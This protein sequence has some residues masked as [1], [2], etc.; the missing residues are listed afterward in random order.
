MHARELREQPISELLRHLLQQA[1]LLMQ[2]ALGLARH[3]LKNQARDAALCA[4]LFAVAG[5]LGTLGFAALTAAFVLAL[6]LALPSW[7]AALIVAV[8]YGAV[9]LAFGL[10]AFGRARTMPMPAQQAMRDLK[11]GIAQMEPTFG[12]IAFRADVPARMRERINRRVSDARHIVAS[13]LRRAS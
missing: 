5:L 6:A 12:A 1:S 10:S 3:E 4:A 13:Y 9:A 2:H 8:I 11:V 7:E